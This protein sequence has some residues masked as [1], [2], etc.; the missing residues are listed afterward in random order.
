L[1][2]TVTTK[3][4]SFDPSRYLESPETAAVYLD[5][6]MEENDPCLFAAALGDVA[7]AQGLMGSEP[8]PRASTAETGG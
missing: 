2:Y 6:I 7:R 3:L 1:D 4:T 8:L 5:S